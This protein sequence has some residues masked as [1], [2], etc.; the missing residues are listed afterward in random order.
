MSERLSFARDVRD[1][2]SASPKCLASR[3]FYDRDGSALFQKIM[4]L[5]EYYLTR[6]ETDILQKNHHYILSPLGRDTLNVIEFGA[7][8]GTKTAIL[9]EA[10]LTKIYSR[11]VRRYVPIDI[12]PDAMASL[13]SALRGRFPS[14]VVEPFIGD[15]A[16]GI[17]HLATFRR[18]FNLVLFLGSNIGNFTP[19]ESKEFLSQVRGALH[20]GDMLLIGFDLKKEKSVLVSAYSDASGV[21]AAF[22]LNLLRRI[23]RELGANFNLDQFSHLAFYNE[24]LGAME[25]YLLSLAEQS[26]TIADLDSEFHF[27][28]GEKVHTEYSFKYSIQDIEQLAAQC[29]FEVV[30]HFS[31]AKKYFV[32]S[33]WR[34]V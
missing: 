23:N 26:V 22:N 31:D 29:G 6:T 18:E 33:L 13:S 1:G 17:E 24:K 10:L 20:G 12:S 15:Y 28:T 30:E 27:A 4:A 11:S 5:P 19:K 21:T 34:A 16:Q 25:S 8:D 7:G 2:L 32:D 14:L 9:L 3:Y